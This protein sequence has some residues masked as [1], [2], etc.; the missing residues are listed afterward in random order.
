MEKKVTIREVAQMAGV[1]I[2]TVSQILNGHEQKF[3]PYTVEKVYAAKRSL[4]YEPDYLARRMV[5][6]HS[7]TIGVILPDVTNPFFG[8]LLKGIE[9]VM[10]EDEFVVMLCNADFNEEKENKY[11]ETFIRRGVDGFIIASS[12]ISNQTL[13]E[14]LVNQGLPFIVLDQKKHNGFSDA[15]ETADFEGGVLAGKHFAEL[16]HEKIA[17]IIPKNAPENV[18]ARLS[19]IQSIYPD[20]LVIDSPLTKAGG[21]QASEKIVASEVTAIFAANDEIALG[22]YQGLNALCKTVPTDYSII[23]YDDQEFNELVEPRLTTI[24]QPTFELGKQSAELLL[25][26]IAHPDLPYTNIVLP[27]SLVER[28]STARYLH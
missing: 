10:Y 27:V 14:T 15:I 9:S 3:S 12:S 2:A 19:G 25:K 7:R 20:C 21:K 26:R 11:L 1:S 24:A 16:G 4:R 17:V 5:G 23:G 28:D 8:T 22:L 18:Q 6:K 13:K